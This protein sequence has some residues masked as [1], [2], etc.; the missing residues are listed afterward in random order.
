[1]QYRQR[2]RRGLHRRSSLYFL[3]VL[4]VAAL[5]AA[6]PLS[7]PNPRFCPFLLIPM[8]DVAA[9]VPASA[10]TAL[11]HLSPSADRHL[12]LQ[13]QPVPSSQLK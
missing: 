13:L 3:L 1:M 11:L 5:V 12:L 10:I 8:H 6:V 2:D 7:F 4:I 9:A